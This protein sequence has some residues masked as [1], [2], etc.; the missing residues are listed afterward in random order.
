MYMA[1]S[2]GVVDKIYN[3]HCMKYSSSSSYVTICI[4][5]N[6]SN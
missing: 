5:V 3:Q 1:S 6:Q 4:A 2:D